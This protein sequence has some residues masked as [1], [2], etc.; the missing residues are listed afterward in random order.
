[1]LYFSF[2]RL[3]VAGNF[4]HRNISENHA[5]RNVFDFKDKF[6]KWAQKPY[7]FVGFFVRKKVL[8]FRNKRLTE[9]TKL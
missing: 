5:R 6:R 7:N 1:V 8:P 4:A 3:P 2:Y 9:V